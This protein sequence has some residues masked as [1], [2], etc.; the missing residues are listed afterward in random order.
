MTPRSVP[1]VVDVTIVVVD[2]NNVIGSVPAATTCAATDALSG[3]E[4]CAVTGY[5]V[6]SLVLPDA[7]EVEVDV[8][9]VDKLVH[10]LLFAA[11]VCQIN[12]ALLGRISANEEM[13]RQAEQNGED[14]V[15]QSNLVPGDQ[16]L[17]G[18]RLRV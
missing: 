11:L 3:P 5:S 8:P 12:S 14:Q 17:E 9:G 15:N 6:V 1:A 16:H 7:P 13:L 2:G 10:L 4:D 18:W